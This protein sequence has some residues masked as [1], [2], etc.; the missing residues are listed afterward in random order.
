[1]PIDALNSP[2]L[3]VEVELLP[4]QQGAARYLMLEWAFGDF[5]IEKLDPRAMP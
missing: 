2:F 4:W 1:V 3:K 5:E